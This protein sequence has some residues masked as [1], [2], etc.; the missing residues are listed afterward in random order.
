[1]VYRVIL[2]FLLFQFFSITDSKGQNSEV[3][4]GVRLQKSVNLYYENGITAQY[5]NNSLYSK[6]LYF[7]LSYVTSRLGSAIGSNAIK[8]D[9]IFL[10]ITYYFRPD[11]ILQPFLRLNTGYFY[12][13]LE[14]K[15]FDDLP[16]SSILLSPEAGIRLK[17]NSPLKVGASFGYNLITGDGRKGPGTLYPVFIQ[18]SITWSILNNTD[19]NEK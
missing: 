10:S 12:S 3:D 13:D 19:Q 1:M 6:R 15:I 5:T 14:E 17:T 16:N 7:G 11:K 4:I 9:N 8:Q 18:S 2:F